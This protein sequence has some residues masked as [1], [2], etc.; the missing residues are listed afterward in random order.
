MQII[1][2]MSGQGVRFKKAGYR[3]LKPLIK[4]D[5]VPMIEHV[6]NLFPGEKEFVF[7]CTKGTATTN[8]R[9][10]L[11]RLMPSGRIVEIEPH[12]L[13]PVHAVLQA[14]AHIRRN[15]PVIVN[16]CDFSVEWDYAHFNRT[17]TDLGCDGCIT[18]YKGFHPHSL[19]TNL[20]AYMRHENN[21]LLEIAEKRCFTDNRMEEYASSGTYYFRSGELLLQYFQKSV[22]SDLRVNGEFYASMPYNLL[23]RDGL[24][25]YIYELKRFMQWG[26]PEDLEEY[27]AWSH[28]FTRHENWRPALPPHDG[29]N[30]IPMAGAGIRFVNEGYA[31]P[32]PLVGVNG[33]T[34]IER[35]LDCLPTSRKWIAVTQST[36][37][38]DARLKRVLNNRSRQVQSLE[39]SYLPEGQAASC[40]VAREHLPPESP[41]LIAPC[42]A[43]TVYDEQL[44]SHM[45]SDPAIDCLV[46][47]FM[48]HPHANR[49]PKQYGWIL[50]SE[51]GSVRQVLCKQRPLTSPQ[52]TPGI[53]GTFWFRKAQYFLQAADKLVRDN[54]RVND[55]FY[56]D[57]CIQALIEMGRNVHIFPVDHYLCLGTPEDVRTY[58]YWAGYFHPR[59]GA[60]AAG[61]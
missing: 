52:T 14:A 1:I 27:Q 40:L 4:V 15:E 57:S 3:E 18:A 19:G 31:D 55:E 54:L 21:Y 7:I 56:V 36:Y 30:L 38:R 2:P 60:L 5:G 35:S 8:L 44:L 34:L 42:D 50:V 51:S 20:Y 26:T 17:M 45:V 29:V 22:E 41:L 32:K 23:V 49:S 16:Y 59:K 47:T 58:E 6:I 33:K 46:W 9:Q 48:N 24:G 25:V 43:V 28:Y 11:T 12:K 53:I 37:L 39:V 61:V 13:G 10:L